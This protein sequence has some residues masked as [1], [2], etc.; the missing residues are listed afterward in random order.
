MKQSVA[1]GVCPRDNTRLAWHEERGFQCQ[2]CEQCT[3]L[4][5][6]PTA[7]V[8]SLPSGGKAARLEALPQSAVACATCRVT[9]RLRV[10]RGTE[11]DICPQCRS[12]WLDAGEWERIT[13]PASTKGA[14]FGRTVALTGA[15]AAGGVALGAAASNAA[16]GGGGSG[17]GSTLTDVGANVAGEVAGEVGGVVLEIVF[18]FLGD[19]LGSLF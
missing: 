9:M 3:G 11:V 16:Q 2:R 15:A 17:I 1:T 12:V 14:K 5:V 8:G 7:L 4:F 6:H 19:A 13:R 18:E 10:H